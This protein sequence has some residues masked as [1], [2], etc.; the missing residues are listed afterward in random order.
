MMEKEF[1]ETKKYDVRIIDR[2]GT[3]DACM[4]DWYGYC[5][6]QRYPPNLQLLQALLNIQFVAILNHATFEG[7]TR[8]MNGEEHQVKR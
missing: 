2:V 4:Q 7:E 5:I 3:G 6:Y 1:Y 8:L